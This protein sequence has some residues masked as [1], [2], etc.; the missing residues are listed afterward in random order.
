VAFRWT[1]A[2]GMVGLGDLPGGVFFSAANGVSADGAVVV[3]RGSSSNGN[4]AFRWTQAGGMV[5][6]GDLPGGG[7]FSA[8][9]GVSADGA[10]VVGRG[11]GGNGDEAF[12]WTQAGGMVGLGDLAGGPFFSDATG[13]SA[14]GSVVVGASDNGRVDRQGPGGSIGGSEAFRW[15][16]AGCEG[17]LGDLPGGAILSAATGV[18]AD[19]AVVVGWS[20]NGL[21]VRPG[22]GGSFI[23][24]SEAFRWTQAGGMQSVAGWLAAAGHPVSGWTLSSARAT[25]R[26][27]SVVV[28]HGQSANGIEAWIARVTPDGSGLIGLNNFARSLAS[29][30]DVSRLGI[31]MPA[32]ALHGAHHRNLA[33]MALI[34]LDGS[35]VWANG[36]YGR[37]NRYD[38]D[39][40]LSEAGACHDFIPG[41]LRAGVGAGK[42]FSWQ[43]LALSG[44]ARLD[45]EYVVVEADWRFD[46]PLTASLTGLYG[47][48]DA[49][50]QRGYLN[51]GAQD[52]SH[53]DTGIDSWALR[54]RLDWN[55]AFRLG[56]VGFSPRIEYTVT[57]VR[58]D[59]FTETNPRRLPRRVR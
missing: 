10:V 40:A 54:A 59:D 58:V 11:N 8:A 36:D 29:L 45:G 56:P 53:G 57:R 50:I 1:Q 55:D 4:E 22:P 19:G 23:G 26:D 31:V 51:A 39:S 44:D 3:G 18:S 5:G 14:D 41:K 12:R 48:Y 20:D 33:D 9:N 30:G 24:G 35:C 37:Y 52:F 27:G 49:D 7:F 46:L 47:G 2:G 28:G 42:G 13:V 43:D 16:Q 34:G 38:A 15:T 21:G 6:L 25:S 17:G 32:L